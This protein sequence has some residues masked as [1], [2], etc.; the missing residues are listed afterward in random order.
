MPGTCA[1]MIPLVREARDGLPGQLQLGLIEI[2]VPRNGH[3]AHPG[4]EP[5]AVEQGRALATSFHP[6]L[7]GETRIHERFLERVATAA[8]A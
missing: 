2:A 4:A 5:V 1:G 7:A 3:V 8:A 6:E